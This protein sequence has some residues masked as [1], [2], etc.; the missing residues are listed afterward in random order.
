MNMVR[1]FFSKTPFALVLLGILAFFSTGC[2][3]ETRSSQLAPPKKAQPTT[4]HGNLRKL[5]IDTN[6]VWVEIADSDSKRREGLMWRDSLPTN[7]GML[8]VFPYAEM[9]SFWMRNTYIPLD[10][11]YVD[12]NWMITD[13][14]HMEPIVDTIFFKSSKPVPYA[15]ELNQGW[16]ETHGVKV[17][18]TVVLH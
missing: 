15:V 1:K 14:H 13:I 17:G 7:Q 16:C 12:D 8:F 11:V 4:K 10:L 5:R 3:Q 18:D 9:Q 2:N 6:T